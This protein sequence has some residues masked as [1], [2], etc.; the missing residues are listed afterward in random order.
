MSIS[1]WKQKWL[2][3][4]VLATLI[5]AL[6]FAAVFGTIAAVNAARAVMRYN[7]VQI[8]EGVYTYFTSYCKTR[9]LAALQASGVTDAVDSAAFFA[10]DRGDGVTYGEDFA[11]YTEEY[12]RTVAVSAW[13]F[14]STVGA[15]S[16][17]EK[18]TIRDSVDDLVEFRADGDRRRFEQLCS[19]YGF[20]YRDMLNAATLQYKAEHLFSAL[21]GQNASYML[22]DTE[23]CDAYF[24]EEYVR[25]QLLF[26]RT[27]DRL[28]K[29]ENG[30]VIY[31]ETDLP[32]RIPLTDTEK[33]ERQSSIASLDAA[34]DNLAGGSGPVITED[35][36]SYFQ[37]KYNDGDKLFDA[38][39]W[40][41]APDAKATQDFAA[42]Y[43]TITEA[44][45]SAEAGSYKKVAYEDGVCYIHPLT[46]DA[47]AYTDEDLSVF[48]SDFA[49]DCALN[50]HRDMLAERTPE[51]RLTERF[52]AFDPLAVPYNYDLIARLS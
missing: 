13:M 8:S 32:E 46:P 30:E 39:G 37:S 20:T 21:Y 10:R 43:P 12:V 14:D 51:V 1:I 35:M 16:R 49:A 44:A 33:A 36:L 7:G 19:A 2:R 27:N 9:Y 6:V 42:L 50:L 17:Q 29:D 31:D 28:R 47:D 45:F 4:T 5:L 24:Q 25:V 38:T 23:A 11:T 48:F 34:I 40:Y 18:T 3:L 22:Y 15:L 41:F 26:I 52:A